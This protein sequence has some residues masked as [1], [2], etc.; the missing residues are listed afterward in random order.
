[1]YER[2]KETRAND[3]GVNCVKDK[4]MHGRTRVFSTACI[5]QWANAIYRWYEVKLYVMWSRNGRKLTSSSLTRPLRAARLPLVSTHRHFNRLNRTER[6]KHIDR[7]ISV[8]NKIV[9]FDVICYAML[10]LCNEFYYYVIMLDASSPCW[11]CALLPVLYLTCSHDLSK[12]LHLF[13][14]S[15]R[16]HEMILCVGMGTLIVVT[17]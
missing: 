4:R 14:T 1:M 7:I 9:S 10:C 2:R 12:L 11:L 15:Y 3:D 5:R 17:H 16:M 6:C 8:E 13:I